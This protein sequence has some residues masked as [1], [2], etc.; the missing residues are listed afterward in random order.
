MTGDQAHLG[1]CLC[2]AIRYR[3]TGEP[4]HVNMCFCTQ[5]R[6]ETGSPMAVFPTYSLARFELLQG[7]LAS[8]RVSDFATRRF[9]RDC[10]S[11]ISWQRDGA[12]EL[13]VFLGTLDEPERIRPPDDQ[14]WTQHRMP[15]VHPH[16][17]IKAY[18]ANRQEG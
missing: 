17:E 5:C 12:A 18:R 15:W 16:P 11:P 2:G 10:G 1:G 14:L 4:A 13:D 9:C 7:E 8:I 3:V 6:R